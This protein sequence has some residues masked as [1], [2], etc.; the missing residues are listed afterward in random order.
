MAQKEIGVRKV[1]PPWTVW[2]VDNLKNR[3]KRNDLHP[4]TCPICSTT[5]EPM[6]YGW[7]CRQH[8]LIKRSWAYEVDLKN[9]LG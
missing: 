1:Q 5:L 2:Q 8:G 7:A 9:N 3:Q 4:Y 6:T